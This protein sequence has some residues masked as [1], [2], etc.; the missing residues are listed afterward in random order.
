M[1][2][3]TLFATPQQS[4]P[5]TDRQ[6]VRVYLYYRLIL[7]IVL[8]VMR[9]GDEGQIHLGQLLPRLYLSVALCYL[10]SALLAPLLHALLFG[11]S[12]NTAR[13]FALFSFDI[14]LFT[15][16]MYSSSGVTSVL[17]NLSLIAV[18]AGNILLQGRIGT[19]LAALATYGEPLEVKGIEHI[20]RGMENP[21][22]KLQA[23]GA[24]FQLTESE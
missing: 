18:A 5:R 14:L 4:L 3:A 17:C 15:L 8:L 16:L 7:A 6:V 13:L 19:L 21:L 24:K 10:L 1:N 9:F 2:V 20:E 22:G 11:S 12:L 23:L